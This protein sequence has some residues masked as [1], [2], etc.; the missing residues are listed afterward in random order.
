MA[1]ESE[2]FMEFIEENPEFYTIM[3]SQ[4]FIKVLRFITE[5]ARTFNDLLLEFHYISK[6]DLE[7]ILAS[8]INIKALTKVKIPEG[9]LYVVTDKTKLFFEKYDKTQKKFFGNPF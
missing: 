8:L 5:K 9:I 4:T 7:L 2:E 1:T 6:Q 3:S